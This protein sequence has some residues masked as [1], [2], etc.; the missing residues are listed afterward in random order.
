M[1]FVY[2]Q[3]SNVNLDWAPHKNIRNLVPYMASINSPEVDD[4]R[5]ITFRV[6]APDVKEVMLGGTILTQLRKEN[7]VPFKKDSVGNWLLKVGPLPRDI[8][9]YNFIIDGL[10]TIDPNNTYTGF[11]NQ[12]GFSIVVVHGGGPS[13][14]D[15]KNVPHGNIIRHIYHS[16]VLNGEREMYVYT[17]PMYDEGKEYPVLYLLGGSGE[18]ASS[19]TFMG[20]INFIADNLIAEN[21]AKPMIIV[22]PNN[23]VVHRRAEDHL[24]KNFDLLEKELR[25]HIIPIIESTYSVSTSRHNRAIAGLS[26]GGR[27]AQ[28][29][30]FNCIDLFASFGL[31]SSAA[32]LNSNPIFFK[33][34]EINSKIDFLFLGAGAFETDETSR[35]KLL[36]DQLTELNIKHEYYIGGNGGHD[37]ITWRHLMYY[38]FLPALWKIK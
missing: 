33:D 26:M 32:P 13:F 17:P 34:P 4:N 1:G 24:E 27:Q 10:K 7:P 23:Q 16:D 20:K 5:M 38:H 2:P 18:L 8:Y 19:W 36:H 9:F 11:A 14:Y 3:Q 25:H 30:G 12:P 6:N 29:T 15:A 37:F 31:L 21:K 28:V 22:M 35:H